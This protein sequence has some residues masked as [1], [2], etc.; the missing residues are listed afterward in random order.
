M[1]IFFTKLV[2]IK[3]DYLLL[4]PQRGTYDNKQFTINN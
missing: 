2:L 1:C 4:S 3:N